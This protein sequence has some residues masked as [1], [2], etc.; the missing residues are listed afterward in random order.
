[1]VDQ[2]LG[3]GYFGVKEEQY[4]VRHIFLL[5]FTGGPSLDLILQLPLV[6]PFV[7]ALYLYALAALF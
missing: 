1:M 3:V 4:V 5:L 7:I 2:L 6:K